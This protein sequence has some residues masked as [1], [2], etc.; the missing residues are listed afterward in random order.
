MLSCKTW[1][2]KVGADLPG[3]VPLAAQLALGQGADDAG[4]GVGVGH[5]PHA[6]QGV[7]DVQSHL[8]LLACRRPGVS[9]SKNLPFHSLRLWLLRDALCH[10]LAY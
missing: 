1:R 3:N 6:W 8:P 7:E 4:E 2:F 5:Q 10:N 9:Y